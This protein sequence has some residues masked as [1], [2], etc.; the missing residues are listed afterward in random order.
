MPTRAEQ[1][2]L[3]DPDYKLPSPNMLG[4]GRGAEGTQQGQRR[5]HRGA[6]GRLRAVRGGCRG[7]RVHPWPDRH[8]IRDRARP[9]GQ[10]RADHRAVPQHRLL[11][12]VTGRADHQPDPGQERGRH[13]GAQQRPGKRRARRRA[14]IPDGVV[15]SSSADRGARQGHRRRLRGGQPGQDAAHP[16]RWCHRRRQ[17]VMPQ[18]A[19]R[20]V[21][22]AGHAGRG[23][24]AAGRP[25]TCRAD[26]VRRHP[27]PGHADRHEPQEGRR[28]ARLGGP[29]DGHALRRP[30]GRRRTP[31]RRL[32]P[33][34]P[35]RGDQAASRQRAGDP[36]VPV[37]ARRGRRAGRPDDGRAP[38]CRG[39]DRP[40]HAA[41]PRRRHPPG[42]GHPAA[43]RRRGDRSDQGERAVAAGVRHVVARRL[44]GHPR[45]AGCREADRPGRRAVPADGRVQADP[46]AG[47]L[48]DRV[49]DQRH[50]QVLQEPARAGVPVRTC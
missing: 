43:E 33:Q 9:G 41:G 25:E 1:L 31:H 5:G 40:D 37:F 45:P 22:D 24:A 36:S 50:G 48:G 39:R 26:F 46:A 34:G 6:A 27:A 4:V 13:R 18:L 38:R 11:G 35:L 49:G 7:H 3:T 28:C 19:A 20:V 15:R 10:G 42:A 21:A 12:E 16:D 30:G 2:A 23:A 47:R 29:R 17:V 44:P 14:A 8:A 32:Q